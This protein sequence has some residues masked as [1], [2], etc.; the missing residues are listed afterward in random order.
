MEGMGWEVE[1]HFSAK[2][3]ALITIILNISIH[4]YCPLPTVDWWPLFLGA[5]NSS[6][7]KETDWVRLCLFYSDTQH[8]G[9]SVAS[10]CFPPQS[11][12]ASWQWSCGEL[13]QGKA[14][15]HWLELP[16]WL[17]AENFVFNNVSQS[18]RNDMEVAEN[19][20]KQHDSK[21]RVLFWSRM[22]FTLRCSLSLV[23]HSFSYGTAF[24]GNVHLS[25]FSL[26]GQQ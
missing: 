5:G 25:I 24:S 20:R 10:G 15:L 16:L 7:S 4:P 22:E 26:Q 1:G 23:T 18:Q 6:S 2:M 8:F 21:S 13:G 9:S 11:V 17:M 3:I 12:E 19:K 14:G